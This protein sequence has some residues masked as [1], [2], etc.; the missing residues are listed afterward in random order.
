VAT[1]NRC[2]LLAVVFL[3]SV[4]PALGQTI[5]D[6]N[7]TGFT[8]TPQVVTITAGDSVRWLWS[9][10]SHT[11]TSGTPCTAD[12]AF[13]YPLNSSNPQVLIPFTTPGTYPYFCIP[14]CGMGMTGTVMV[15]PQV[16]EPDPTG[17][18]CRS[19]T[20]PTPG[21]ECLPVCVNYD[22]ATGAYTVV[23]CDCIPYTQCHVDVTGVGAGTACV[24]P[25]NGSGTADL[26][27]VGCTYDTPNDDM[28]IIDGLPPATTIEIDATWLNFLNITR[29]PGGPLGGEVESFNA[30][31]HLPL[32]GT[33]S[34]A[35]FNRVIDMAT[36]DETH[37]APRTAG[38]PI[39]SFPADLYTLQGQITGDPDFD[40]LRITAGT[41]FGL[42][43]PGHT[44]LTQLPGGNWAVN[45]FFDITYRIDFV[46]AP[47]GPLGG[48]S[49]S[50]TGTIRFKTGLGTPQCFG[51]CPQPGE[52]CTRTV[53]AGPNGTWNICCRCEN[54]PQECLP[55]P[56]GQ[57]CLPTTCPI[58]G[59]ECRPKC[60]RQISAY[61][62]VVVDCD[63][64][65]PEECHLEFTYGTNCV[66][67]DNGSGTADLPPAGCTYTTPT[68][69]M[70][71]IDGLPPAT[72]IDID[73]SQGNFVCPAGGTGVCSFAQGTTC[74]WA[75]GSLSGMKSCADADLFMP[76]VGT[77]SL[78]GFLRNIPLPVSMEIHTAPRTNGDPVQSFDTVL[79]R[80]FGQIV[81]DPDF[82]LLRVVGGT[83]FGLPSPGHT[84]LTQLPGGTWAVDSFFDIT[85]RIDFVGAPGGPLAGRSGSTTGTAR[86]TTSTAFPSP[87]CVGTCPPGMHCELTEGLLPDGTVGL[88]CNCVPDQ[89]EECGPTPDG[90]ACLPVVCPEPTEECLPTCVHVG[91]DGTTTV[92]DCRCRDPNECHIEI[93]PGATPSCVGD[94]PPGKVCMQ[95]VTPTSTGTRYCCECVDYPPECIPTPDGQGCEPYVCPVPPT[96]TECQPRCVRFD[97]TTGL[98]TVIDCDCRGTS[99][100][101]PFWQPGVAPF[102]E[103]NCP[104]GKVCEENIVTN[105]DGTIDVC[106]DC[107]TPTCL[108]PG[109][110]NGDGLVNGLDIAGFVRCFMGT[111]LLVDHCECADMNGDLLVDLADVQPFVDRLL[112]G[113]APCDP[114]P[115]P[116]EDLLVDFTTG[117][118]EAGG[119]IPVGGNDDGWF[120]TLDAGGGTV[121]RP[122]QVINSHPVWHTIPGSQWISAN[123]YGPN[124][125]YEYEFCFCLDQ[126]FSNPVLSIQL[127]VDDTGE[128]YLNGNFVGNAASFAMPNPASITVTNPALFVVGKNCLKV[129]VH[130]IGGPP[131]GL[132]LAGTFR[133]KHGKCC[134]DGAKLDK[135]LDSGVDDATSGLIPVGNDDDTWDVTVDPSGGSVPRPA[136]VITPHPAWL[137]IPGTQWISAA[138]YGPNGSYTYRSCFCLDPRFENPQLLLDLRADD[139]ATVYLNGNYVG[140]TPNGW[141]FNTPQPTRVF[142]TNPAFFRPFENCIEIVVVNGGGVVTGLNVAGRI[143]ADKG[144]CCWDQRTACCFRSGVCYVMSEEEC[145]AA[146]GTPLGVGTTCQGDLDGNGI[147]DACQPPPPYSCCLENGLCV[148]LAPGESQCLVGGLLITGP[149]GPSVA[150]CMT[151]GTCIDTSEVCCRETGGTPQGPGTSCATFPCALPQEYS[152]CLDDGSCVDLAPGVA[153]CQ[154]GTLMLG[155]CGLSQAC[156]LP[157]GTCRDVAEACC[158][159]L[160]GAPQGPGTLCLE[161]E[162]P[163]PVC[164]PLPGTLECRQ[165]T[166]AGPDETCQPRCVRVEAGTYRVLSVVECDCRLTAGCAARFSPAPENLWQGCGGVCPP[167]APICQA[168]T[169]DNGDG[170]L[171]ICC[172]E[173]QTP[174]S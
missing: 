112:Y 174:G 69:D 77:G 172:G 36:T 119:F 153:F 20:C 27:P 106:C 164:E 5:H 123:Y 90:S 145:M 73:A 44:T 48:M 159:N 165:T 103:S 167:T 21:Q 111:S 62:F 56:A 68:D 38:D 157:D 70:Q 171:T 30:T 134:C 102:C 59:Q 86:F 18:S 42:P 34:L 74:A 143:T 43:S 45:S 108:C 55:D 11:V 60:V 136:T 46:G 2:R 67:S 17:R 88:C 80:M 28:N 10:G 133:A 146:D 144:Q 127:R 110:V 1:F 131:T 84:T 57:G 93:I 16:C 39:Q 23:E 66:V 14:H 169:T 109:D 72:T 105:A 107:I 137:T 75:G 173:C 85:Y 65:G 135:S 58:P 140:A 161:T 24:Q 81:G 104:T 147:D 150:C 29:T 101:R 47:G 53:T 19:T 15:Q 155:P 92:E 138:V 52:T 162:C 37:A 113:D 154:S 95:R 160:G 152:C 51:D 63:C 3:C 128:V 13:S 118:D 4:A 49:G 32:V 50:T 9:G 71:I 26:P 78:L 33:G 151:D 8:F 142:V 97:P 129:V 130:N 100:C 132:N 79:Y 115:C 12:G 6:V 7:Q 156:C 40:L 124:G 122:A 41:G 35:G 114:S 158:Y 168:T 64:V 125:D 139:A 141:A 126:R 91:F 76:M 31:L 121:P 117:V 61:E 96:D 170:T 94:C 87:V 98:T 163:P 83:D 149:C 166:C 99:E 54:P 89:P 25:D 22:P 120:V 82:D 116:P 148:D